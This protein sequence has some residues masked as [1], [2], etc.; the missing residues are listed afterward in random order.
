MKR[1][2]ERPFRDYFNPQLDAMDSISLALPGH[3][4][5]SRCINP[6]SVMTGFI[7]MCLLVGIFSPVVL[8]LGIA[9]FLFLG[10][11]YLHTRSIAANL[12]IKRKL[13][14]D[15]YFEFEEIEVK[16]TIL[17]AS[18]SRTPPLKVRD[19]FGPSKDE[20]VLQDVPQLIDRESRRSFLY[21]RSADAGMG[22]KQVGPISVCFTDP[23]GF[24]EFEVF[25]E[26]V[27]DV[28]VLPKVEEL[29]QLNISGSAH[30]QNYGVYNMGAKGSSVNFV[31]IREYE[32]GDSL[33]NIAWKLSAK[34]GEL[35]VKEFEK[36][37]NAE[38]SIFLNLEPSLQIGSKELSTWELIKD[39]TLSIASQQ[40]RQY[41]SV[42][43]F[44]QN[45]FL[46]SLKGHQGMHDLA[47]RLITLDPVT[48]VYS[49]EGDRP[50][51]LG[52]TSELIK[53]YVGMHQ[54]GSNI[55]VI[56]P[57]L[58]A[59][60][61]SLCDSLSALKSLGMNVYCVLVDTG[62][63]YTKL[64]SRMDL[65]VKF[66]APAFKGLDD[67]VYRLKVSGV[68]VIVLDPETEVPESFLKAGITR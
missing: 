4:R 62:A 8:S 61:N 26:E 16:Y 40:L 52:S 44:T 50:E 58:T 34:K 29:P 54:S 27:L 23:F 64:Q 51:K 24:F 37:V 13:P 67:V 46:E 17:N 18:S 66:A 3:V 19:Y 5:W 49:A 41:N 59:D 35:L 6:L 20:V 60:S 57:F 43:F 39:V 55:I 7:V 68:D 21:K 22:I 15:R 10:L 38:V 2:I 47:R 36:M 31:G 1:V 28:E 33:K 65:K 63:F 42:K 56:T 53:K 45:L 9:L 25:G 11:M 32:Q 48:D 30:S 14:R 12:Y